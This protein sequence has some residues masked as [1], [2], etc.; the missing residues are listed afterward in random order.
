MKVFPDDHEQ[1]V[2]RLIVVGGEAAHQNPD[3]AVAMDAKI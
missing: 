2:P 1:W 3:S